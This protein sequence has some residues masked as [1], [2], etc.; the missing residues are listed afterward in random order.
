MKTRQEIE[1]EIIELTK[2]LRNYAEDIKGEVSTRVESVK[3]RLIGSKLDLVHK[4]DYR[5]F[6]IRGLN[7]KIR[8][9]YNY[10]NMDDVLT[11]LD[12]VEFDVEQLLVFASYVERLDEHFK[13]KY[14]DFNYRIEDN[15]M[16][17]DMTRYEGYYRVIVV[18]TF[19]I[20]KDATVDLTVVVRYGLDTVMCV[21][22]KIVSD[23][24]EFTVTNE[25]TTSGYDVLVGYT[26]FTTTIENVR[27]ETFVEEILKV[28]KATEGADNFVIKLTKDFD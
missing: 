5:Y 18:S 1:Q 19:T 17:V 12:K 4:G 22:K 9:F 10:N 25:L 28:V 11:T 13:G 6:S 3:G 21:E 8:Q 27:L 15:V 24:I 26:M 16:T 14:E 23:D 7:D 2:Q 20:N